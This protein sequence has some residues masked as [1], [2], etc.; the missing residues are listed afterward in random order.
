MCSCVFPMLSPILFL[1]FWIPLTN[2]QNKWEDVHERVTACEVNEIKVWF[3]SK[4]KFELVHALCFISHTQSSSFFHIFNKNKKFKKY[5]MLK[6]NANIKFKLNLGWFKY[7]NIKNLNN[8]KM[9]KIIVL[10]HIIPSNN[11]LFC[12]CNGKI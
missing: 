8:N 10:S 6:F 5:M 3:N 11:V 1:I 9:R 7:L 12:P 4:T 2:T